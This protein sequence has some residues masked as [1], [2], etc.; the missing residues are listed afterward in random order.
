MVHCANALR[1]IKQS[2]GR[3]A[4]SSS[5]HRQ[6]GLTTLEVCHG[7]PTIRADEELD[8]LELCGSE[9][10]DNLTNGGRRGHPRGVSQ[11]G[12]PLARPEDQELVLW[13]V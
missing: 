12:I 11:L 7:V 9:G 3:D 5:I 10:S 4:Q 8:K 6:A 13:M 1:A 2:G